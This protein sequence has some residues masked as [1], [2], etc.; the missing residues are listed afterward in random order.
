MP[1]DLRKQPAINWAARG[2]AAASGQVSHVRLLT[3]YSA[4]RLETIVRACGGAVCVSV[5][6]RVT[7]HIAGALL[8][9]LDAVD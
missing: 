3:R 7:Y 8:M 5:K 2:K 9:L 4:V 1:C 6:P